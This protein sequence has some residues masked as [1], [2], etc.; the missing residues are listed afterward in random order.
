MIII[1]NKLSVRPMKFKMG[2]TKSY[3]PKI[4]SQVTC[5]G[6]TE[7]ANLRSRMLRSFL[8]LKTL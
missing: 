7:S 2:L 4:S 1:L 8:L 3:L 6:P 5:E